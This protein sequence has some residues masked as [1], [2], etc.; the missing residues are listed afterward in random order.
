MLVGSSAPQCPQLRQAARSGASVTPV[1]FRREGLPTNLCRQAAARGADEEGRLA[2]D[3]ARRRAPPTFRLLC[4]TAAFDAANW[5]SRPKRVGSTFPVERPVHCGNGRSPNM[6]RN[7]SPTTAVVREWQ[8]P[9]GT[10]SRLNGGI[11]GSP[12]GANR[13][14]DVGHR[15]RPK[16]PLWQSELPVFA[17]ALQYYLAL[18]QA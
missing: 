14:I 5:N 1:S 9:T 18:R 3:A 7:Q 8:L 16:R 4:L 6:S 12:A 10:R 15:L 13:P 17:N 11:R 2:A